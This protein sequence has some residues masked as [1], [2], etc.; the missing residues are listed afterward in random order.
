MPTVIPVSDPTGI[1]LTDRELI[2]AHVEG[3]QQ[4]FTELVRRHRDRMW[5]VALRTLGDR[6]EAAD[7]L[8]DALISAF[9][10]AGSY[11]GD[12]AVTTWLHRVVVNACLDR[13]RRR[14]AR[15]ADALGER[16]VAERVDE[17]RR[18][19]ARVD[20]QAA[21]ATLPEAQ[22]TALVLVD[23]QDYSVSEAAQLLG[24][25]EG[26]VK[27]RCSRGRTA[28]ALL[29]RPSQ[30]AET[31]GSG[32]NRAEPPRVPSTEAGPTRSVTSRSRRINGRDEGRRE[33]TDQ[34]PPAPPNTNPISGGW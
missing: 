12:A 6:E 32:G 34:E 19:E 15:P 9:R 5:G 23:L 1:P 8:Q 2:A 30:T 33:V 25:A 16:D 24:V 13:L 21:L 3:D 10:N 22:R 7:A 14:K 26:T 20:V 4:A 29:L 11:R 17:H 31:S 18:T 28:L 27:S